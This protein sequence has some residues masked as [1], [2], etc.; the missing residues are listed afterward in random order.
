MASAFSGIF[1]LRA[2]T[3]IKDFS[4]FE[5]VPLPISPLTLSLSLFLSLSHPRRV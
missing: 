1:S 5:I 3:A 2:S 4:E